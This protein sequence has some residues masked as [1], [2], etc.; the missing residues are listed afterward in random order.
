[1]IITFSG[2]SGSG[3]TT[4][5]KRILVSNCF[6]KVDIVVKQ[7]DSFLFLKI[8][9]AIFG[10]KI[11]STYVESKKKGE[12]KSKFWIFL[13]ACFVYIEFLFEYIFY[14]NLFYKKVIIRDRYVVDYLI[15]VNNNLGLNND[16]ITNLYKNFPRPSLSFYVDVNNKVAIKRNMHTKSEGWTKN[17]KEFILN[18][19]K[20]YRHLTQ[21]GYIYIEDEKKSIFFINFKLKMQGIKSISFSGADGTGKTTLTKNFARILKLININS[22]IVHFYHDNLLFKLLK[23]LR[24]VRTPTMNKSYYKMTRQNTKRVK[25]E[26]KSLIWAAAHF[27]DSYIQ[28]IF[29]NI[30]VGNRIIIFDRYFYDYLIS[31]KYLNIKNHFFFSNFIPKPDIGVVVVVDPTVAH[32]RKPENN[33]DFFRFCDVEYKNVSRQYQLLLLDANDKDE[34]KLVGNLIKKIT[35]E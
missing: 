28:Y 32:R 33:L 5:I 14:E 1:M 26:G 30:F 11:T 2:C 9:K 27:L 10:E 3:K 24:I 35:Y 19:L 22:K 21:N 12:N 16:L 8:T 15:T 20:S 17:P 4:I 31:F 29:S 23:L 6:K 25:L 34:N 13:Y 7:E 18:V